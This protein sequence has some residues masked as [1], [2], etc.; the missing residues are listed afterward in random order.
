MSGLD[1]WNP[2]KKTDKARVTRDKAE[3]LDMSGVG[4]WNTD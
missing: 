3:R 1:L 4:L 2:T